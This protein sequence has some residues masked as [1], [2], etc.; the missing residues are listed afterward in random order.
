MEELE[1]DLLKHSNS[2]RL[3]DDLTLMEIRFK[4]A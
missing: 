2:I 3:E 4:E 1:E